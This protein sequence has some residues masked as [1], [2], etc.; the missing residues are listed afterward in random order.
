MQQAKLLKEADEIRVLYKNYQQ[1]YDI[2]EKFPDATFILNCDTFEDEKF[3]HALTEFVTLLSG[4]LI[5]SLF[6]VNDIKY[7]EELKLPYYIIHPI[8]TIEQ[9]R[10]LKDLGVCYALI[11][12]QILH[13][14]HD[15]KKIGV[16]LRA[17]PNIA[18]LDGIPR[19]NGI[20]GNWIR[21]ENIDDYG[22]FIDTIEF[23]TQTITRE[24]GL[25]NI[26][27]HDKEWVGELA[28]IVQDLNFE[29]LNA[30]IPNTECLTRMNCGFRCKSG[31]KC[32]IC[33][34]LLAIAQPQFVEAQL[35]ENTSNFEINTDEFMKKI[36]KGVP[37]NV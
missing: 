8:Q 25:F 27:K 28:N 20:Y 18:H 7:A 37:K 5:L 26:Y 4:R 2:Y 23:G 11:D 19:R 34:Q 36:F 32:D 31:N 1:I 3:I 22:I 13:Q 21:P 33:Y 10:A 35:A 24:Q 12:N 15:A 29:T 14:L 16:P 9:L 30:S 17:I 6:S